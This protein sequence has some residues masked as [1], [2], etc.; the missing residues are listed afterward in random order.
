MDPTIYSSWTG[1]LGNLFG[2]G[3]NAPGILGGT[4]ALLGLVTGKY[5][6]L[7]LGA[8]LFALPFVN[9]LELSTPVIMAIVLIAVIALIGGKK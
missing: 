2:S 5:F 7:F 3:A 9:N 6:L 1:S 8:S 4:V